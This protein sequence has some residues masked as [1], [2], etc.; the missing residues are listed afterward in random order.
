MR[1]LALS[2]SLLL[3]ALAAALAATPEAELK[4][5]D[6]V[7]VIEAKAGPPAPLKDYFGP[8]LDGVNLGGRREA[9]ARLQWTCANLPE[10]DYTVGLLV[11]ATNYLA[12][13]EF[14]THQLPLYHN[15][16]WL[17][18]QNHSEP[19]HPEQASDTRHYQAEM[20]SLPVHLKP[21]DSLMA[22]YTPDGANLVVG[23]LRLYRQPPLDGVQRLEIPSSGKPLT[24]W[25][26]GKM[27]DPQR[28]GEEVQQGRCRVRSACGY[29]RSI[30]CSACCWTRPRRS[31]CSLTSGA[32]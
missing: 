10:G 20:Y 2:L 21:G 18:W 9:K 15:D 8:G 13:A 24:Y 4:A 6:A 19:V 14:Y 5:T 12:F 11:A 7:A 3:L 1:T 23:P 30:T 27:L 25:L 29:R 22:V 32:R 28:Q 17:Y 26:E 31:S 16:R